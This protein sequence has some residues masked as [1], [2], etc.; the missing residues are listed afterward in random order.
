MSSCCAH[1]SCAE[2]TGNF[3][4]KR[5]K[6]YARSFRKGKFE[7]IQQYLIEEIKKEPLEG[8]ALLDIGC[9]VGK[10]HLTLLQEGAESAMGV[11][12]SEEMLN[13]AKS[14]AQQFKLDSK[15]LYRQADFMEIA[16]T[17]HATDITILDKVI[18]CYENFD[19]LIK[20]SADKTQFLYALTY[21]SSSFLAE[22][23]IKAGIVIAK[24][25]RS[26]F[27]PYWHQWN[28]V[29]ELLSQQGFTLSCSKKTL[30]WQV[31]VFKK[32]VPALQ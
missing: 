1:P 20:T 2:S 3:F 12:M 17:V 27:R 10:L 25:F 23:L 4:S 21:P 5:S 18:C 30:L 8:K 31:S 15:V 28:R 29:H 11:D 9:G 26:N 19:G 16:D 22:F 32:S 14:F 13:H 6:S 24:I 7:K